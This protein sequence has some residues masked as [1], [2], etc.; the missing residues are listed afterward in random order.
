MLKTLMFVMMAFSGSAFAQNVEIQLIPAFP[1]LTM[2]DTMVTDANGNKM[3]IPGP[4][5]TANMLI[6]NKTTEDVILA[7]QALTITMVNGGSVT[8]KQPVGSTLPAGVAAQLQGYYSL[9][10]VPSPEGIIGTFTV[11]GNSV[12]GAPF[13]ASVDFTVT[14]PAATTT[15][16][17]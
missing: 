17:P 15:T 13:S 10:G 11:S 9:A 3:N 16:A 5:F 12:S 7:D 1:V 8:T 6:I 14:A 4:W 2:T